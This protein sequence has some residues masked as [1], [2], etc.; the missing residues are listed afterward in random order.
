MIIGNYEFK[1]EPQAASQ[2]DIDTISRYYGSTLPDDYLQILNLAYG[3]EGTI[4]RPGNEQDWTIMI[5][6]QADLLDLNKL[7][8][9]EEWEPNLMMVGSNGGGEAYLLAR[10]TDSRFMLPWVRLPDLDFGDYN[11][12]SRLEYRFASLNDM[13]E[14]QIKENPD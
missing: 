14:F 8:N 6:Y 11:P 4:C 10:P 9:L 5:F 2:T 12:S 13:I 7:A 1:F 3:F